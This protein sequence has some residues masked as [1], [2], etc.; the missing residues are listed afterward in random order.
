MEPS[1][2]RPTSER[3]ISSALARLTLLNRTQNHT[4]LLPSTSN[5]ALKETLSA[6]GILI[7]ELV[8][9][10]FEY[11]AIPS[12]SEEL[13]IAAEKALTKGTLQTISVDDGSD[14]QFA[15]TIELIKKIAKKEQFQKSPAAYMGSWPKSDIDA[16]YDTKVA[17]WHSGVAS[18]M[19]YR[20]YREFFYPKPNGSQQMAS[21]PC[22]NVY[23]A[24]KFIEDFLTERAHTV[25]HNDDF[26]QPVT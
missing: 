14:T 13:V 3:E 21:L 10:V 15:S 22:E 24:F 20:E 9:L 23:R 18:R 1:T 2:T 7:P 8:Q 4:D 16:Y 12:L 17:Q 6:S 11:A 25:S 19:T 5:E 26:N